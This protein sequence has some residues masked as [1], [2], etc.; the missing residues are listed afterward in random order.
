MNKRWLYAVYAL[1]V[2]VAI[3]IGVKRLHPTPS[4]PTPKWQTTHPILSPLSHPLALGQPWTQK[5]K[6]VPL[7][8]SQL[9]TAEWFWP[10][11]G[12]SSVSYILHDGRAR[13]VVD[14]HT[15]PL[16]NPPDNPN[17]QFAASTDGTRLGWVNP[18]GGVTVLNK[19]GSSDVRSGALAVAF[20]GQGHPVWLLSSHQV[21][22]QRN[23]LGWKVP[24]TPAESHPFIDGGR[25]IVTDRKGT[26]ESTA[27]PGGQIHI[28]ARVRARRW[29][30][31]FTA[32][33]VDGAIAVVLER[34]APIPR[35]LVVFIQGRS[36]GW[37][38][39]ASPTPPEIGA[40]AGRLILENIPQ[41]NG[42]LAVMTAH[43]IHPLSIGAG[44]FSE[45]AQGIIWQNNNGFT[46]LYQ[47][48]P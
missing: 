40:L 20:N 18:G 21:Q 13:W 11:T 15:Y 43:Q 27:I 23:V 14:G 32:R 2:L 1:I 35:Y 8:K 3:G 47:V 38:R 46:D 29:P 12:L 30:S 42:N 7:P 39:F 48:S 45:S 28:L 44:I 36:V 9:S 41:A 5:T 31:L 24:G 4:T 6:S 26:V 37:Y 19:H 33:Y 16:K 34:P 22:V 17:D 10:I 25:L